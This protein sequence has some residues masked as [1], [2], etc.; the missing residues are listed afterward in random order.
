MIAIA[1]ALATALCFFFSIGL[2]ETWWLAWLAP[3]P[4]LWFAFG[5]TK[6]WQAFLAAWAGYSLG[7]T[8]M[9]EAYAGILPTTVLVLGLVGPSFFF[10]VAVI[11]ARYVSRA[12]H[13]LAGV[14]AFAAL[15]TAFDFLE[16]FNTGGGSVATPATAEVFVPALIQSASL[17]GVWGIT[18]LLGF[19]SAGLALSVRNRKLLPAA[20]AL[21]LF[22]AN[23]AFGFARIST[24]PASS[25]R[26]ALID[27]D[28]MQRAA[29]SDN[30]KDTDDTVDAYVRTVR[31]LKGQGVK[32][33][34]LPEKI[35]IVEAAWQPDAKSKLAAVAREVDAV[36]VAGFDARDARGSHN[37]SWA[38]TPGADAPTIYSKRRLVPGL[39]SRYTI[40][41]G[42]VALRN[43]IGLEICK[44]MD[45]QAMIRT[46]ATAN[47][48]ALLAVPA[49]D[50]GKDASNHARVALLRSV[51]NGVPMA[52]AARNGLLTLNDRHGRVVAMKATGGDFVT[53]IGDLPL[54][55]R[56]G[57]TL[58]DRI[59]DAFG[60]LCL[61]IGVGLVGLGLARRRRVP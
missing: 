47:K 11:G 34:V 25:V 7:A 12:V 14:L 5:E 21:A 35:A 51:E 56:G 55:G 54:Y 15:W 50:F 9:L 61:I 46:D 22:A 48:P 32:L 29:D 60:W 45:F 38:F 26:T 19:V 43:G 6:R 58:Y 20:L 57:R 52:R 23:A 40:G 41:T 17:V 8:S 39:E 28:A 4:V 10:A 30:Q 49:W 59:G 24:P 27:T 33:I 53:L 1:C 3:V 37:E 42:P 16:S 36:V 31:A 18:F 2:G 13:P 44:D